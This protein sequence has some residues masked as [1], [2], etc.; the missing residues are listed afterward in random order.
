M[1]LSMNASH[2]DEVAGLGSRPVARRRTAWQ[3]KIAESPIRAEH[4]P[5]LGYA[6]AVLRTQAELFAQSLRTYA[7]H[8]GSIRPIDHAIAL[9]A[10]AVGLPVIGRHI[11]P[12][13]GMAALGLGGHRYAGGIVSGFA[14]ARLRHNRTE[15]QRGQ[16]AATGAILD[17]ALRGVVADAGPAENRPRVGCPAPFLRAPAQR[18]YVH[19][20]SVPYGEHPDQLLDIWR[21]EGPADRLAPVLVFIPGGA[22]VFGSRALQ[23]HTLMAHLAR[24]GWI[25]LS[26][27]YRTSPR[28]RWPR[29]MTDVKAAIAWAHANARTLNGDPN[30]VA[31]AGCSAGGHL[32]TLAALTGNKPQWQTALGSDADTTV[33]AAVSLYGAYD[34]HSRATEEQDRFLEFLERVIVKRTQASDPDLFRAASPITHVHPLAPPFLAVHG[35]KDG[36]L[37]VAGARAFV[38]RLRSVSRSSVSYVELPGAGHGFDLIDTERTV[39]VVAAVGRFLEHAYRQQRRQEITP[40][41]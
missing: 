40:A 9:S 28:H 12:L 2:V 24:Q 29:Q 7:Q 25:C 18:R 34:W 21:T 37:P 14:R 6:R 30:F 36:L 10:A 8:V 20:S 26:I 31:V 15:W 39:P 1:Q 13:A 5:S 16:R 32:A 35:S 38:D 22:W 19:R 3:Q 33:D 17:E 11:E 4:P 27:Q 41:V 23:G